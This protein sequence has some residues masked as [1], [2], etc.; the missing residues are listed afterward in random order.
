[1]LWGPAAGYKFYSRSRVI[2]LCCCRFTD[3]EFGHLFGRKFHIAETDWRHYVAMASS[4]Y[5]GHVSNS[6]SNILESQ[7]IY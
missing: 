3:I 2:D 4:L 1:M 7:C 6:E 5:D